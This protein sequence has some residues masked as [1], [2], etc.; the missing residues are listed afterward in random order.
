MADVAN[1]GSVSTLRFSSPKF[2]TKNSAVAEP[3]YFAHQMDCKGCVIAA[4]STT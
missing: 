4:A 3:V 1:L 2:V